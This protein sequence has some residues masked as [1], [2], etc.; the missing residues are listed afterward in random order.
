[1]RRHRDV[2]FT[3]GTAGRDFRCNAFV[4]EFFI[5]LGNVGLSTGLAGK[6]GIQTN[7]HLQTSQFFGHH[8]ADGSGVASQSIVVKGFRSFNDFFGEFAVCFEER[9]V[10]VQAD[11]DGQTVNR[12]AAFGCQ[13]NKFMGFFEAVHGF[14]SDG[15]GVFAFGDGP[16]FVLS[17]VGAVERNNSGVGD[18][19]RHKE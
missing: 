8:G 15:D 10:F 19:G 5:E 16:G 1:M 7:D 9:F 12:C 3:D 6:K 14:R 18:S 17:E 11:T 13:K 2:G 4:Q